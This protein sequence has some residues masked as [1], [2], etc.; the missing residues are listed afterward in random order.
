[1]EIILVRWYTE[2]LNAHKELQ[3]NCM[4]RIIANCTLFRT[5]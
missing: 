2:K 1:M 5:A 3:P 4:I